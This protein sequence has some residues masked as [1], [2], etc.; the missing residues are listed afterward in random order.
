MK[1]LVNKIKE[2]SDPMEKIIS[3]CIADLCYPDIEQH[4]QKCDVIVVPI[5]SCEQHSKHLP[6]GTDIYPCL[7]ISKIAC[8]KADVLYTP[9]Q[10]FGYTPHHL[11]WTGKGTGTITLRPISVMGVYYDISRSLIHHGYNKIV[12]V[13]G[14]ASNLKVMDPVLRKIRYETGAIVMVYKP[15]VER[16][17]GFLEDILEGPQE[18][19]PGWHSGESE[20][21]AMLHLT[22]EL[23]R[24]ERAKT[25]K[26]H[27]PD[28]LPDSFMKTDGAPTIGFNGYEYFNMALE[29]REFTDTGTM[30][31]PSRGSKEKGKIMIERFSQHLAEALEELK[32][33]K[34][35][36]EN[37]EFK[38]RADWV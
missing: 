19:T 27:K 30:G 33:L 29:H 14:H 26:A 22:P 36:I 7:E 8:E 28:W 5:G 37:R 20:T 2:R 3:H 13:T 9:I 1:N 23:V 25:E 31:N 24:M 16:Y 10:P 35:S 21:S 17:L 11:G 12:Y 6:L 18:E 15:W 32:P 34:V 38:N 4:L